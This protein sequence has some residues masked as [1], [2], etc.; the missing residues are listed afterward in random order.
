MKITAK[1]VIVVACCRQFLTLGYLPPLF[2]AIPEFL[3]GGLFGLVAH[4][5]PL[6]RRW[7]LDNFVIISMKIWQRG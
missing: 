7:T 1:R 4:N 2:L 5:A 6:R 3:G